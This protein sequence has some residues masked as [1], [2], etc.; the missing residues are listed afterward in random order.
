MVLLVPHIIWLFNNDFET[1]S[2]AIKRSAL[3]E[4]EIINHIK[5][6][7]IFIFKQIGILLP[8]LILSWTLIKK[9]K[10][11]INFNDKKLIFLFF[12]NILPIFMMLVVSIIFG[13]KVR[14]AWMVPFYL[15][16]GI[17]FIYLFKSLINIKKINL[18]INGFLFL[19]FL[20]PALY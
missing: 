16:F 11:K 10:F 4:K 5:F 1:I 17:L 19:F 12:I 7:L 15:Y 13:S 20:S 8:F 9:F 14:T 18:F 3:D 6:P 2:Y